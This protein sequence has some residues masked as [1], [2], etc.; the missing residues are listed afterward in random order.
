[1]G[2]RARGYCRPRLHAAVLRQ[3]ICRVLPRQTSHDACGQSRPGHT[4]A[5]IFRA[6]AHLAHIAQAACVHIC[7]DGAPKNVQARRSPSLHLG[8]SQRVA[9]P[10]GHAGKRLR[11]D[12]STLCHRRRRD[13][14]RAKHLV[15]R[16]LF[17][18][19][20]G[21]DS[22]RVLP[23]RRRQQIPSILRT[24]ASLAWQARHQQP[25]RPIDVDWPHH[26][27]RPGDQPVVRRRRW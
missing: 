2:S 11:A 4:T 12:G 6:A 9:A 26:L 19:L 27:C 10:L 22:P 8:P 3:R 21:S 16:C 25:A 23:P 17:I 24:P 5:L 1:M 14:H 13:P 7:V 20:S 15:R 18:E